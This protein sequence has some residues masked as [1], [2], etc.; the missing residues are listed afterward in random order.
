[1][2]PGNAIKIAL[3]KKDMNQTELAQKLSIS[4]NQISIW[5]NAKTIG[6]GPLERIAAALDMKPSELM[7]LGE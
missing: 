5:C 3:I 1:M 7:A 2:N 4:K 6:S